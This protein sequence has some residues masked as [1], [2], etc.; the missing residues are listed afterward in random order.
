MSGFSQRE[1]AFENKFAFDQ[2]KRF[3]AEA[4]RDKLLAKWVGERAKMTPD[5]LA[6]YTAEV[7][8]S[9]LKTPGDADVLAK[10]LGDLT[11]RGV[12]VTEAEVRAEMARCHQDAVEQTAR[13]G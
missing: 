8:Q 3:R 4:R 11:K 7:I 10:I 9:D 6:K 12:S 2:A 13:E 1:D 5:E